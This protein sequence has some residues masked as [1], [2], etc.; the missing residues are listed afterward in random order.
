MIY[1]HAYKGTTRLESAIAACVEVKENF[2]AVLISKDRY[3]YIDIHSFWN[4]TGYF[5]SCQEDKDICK[6]RENLDKIILCDGIH[7]DWAVV[8]YHEN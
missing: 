7:Y 3:A 1:K 6:L 4:Y 8:K 5:K 2:E